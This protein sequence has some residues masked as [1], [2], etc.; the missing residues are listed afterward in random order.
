MNIGIGVKAYYEDIGEQ[1]ERRRFEKRHQAIV[2]A[3]RRVRLRSSIVSANAGGCTEL[4]RGF[5]EQ[6]DSSRR[7]RSGRYAQIGG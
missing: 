7:N 1:P 5:A 6:K 2:S 3:R 4:G